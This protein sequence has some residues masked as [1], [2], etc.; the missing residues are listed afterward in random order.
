MAAKASVSGSMLAATM[1]R[2]ETPHNRLFALRCRLGRFEACRGGRVGKAGGR[3]SERSPSSHFLPRPGASVFPSSSHERPS[4]RLVRAVAAR[5]WIGAHRDPP[6]PCGRSTAG[7]AAAAPLAVVRS[8]AYFVGSPLPG[9]RRGPCRPPSSVT[10]RGRANGSPARRVHGARNRSSWGPSV[11][12]WLATG[13]SV[14][15]PKIETAGRVE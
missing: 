12:P 2:G 3:R 4:H 7:T 9:L 1:R 5:W 11:A 6:R 8:G 15:G 10:T 14:C 13:G